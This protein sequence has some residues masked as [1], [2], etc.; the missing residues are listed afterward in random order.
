M[1][2]I[3]PRI[4]MSDISHCP[5]G[6]PCQTELISQASAHSVPHH[7]I[8]F[9]LSPDPLLIPSCYVSP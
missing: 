4:V 5:I 7:S 3:V 1:H 6:S 2:S 9:A 8:I